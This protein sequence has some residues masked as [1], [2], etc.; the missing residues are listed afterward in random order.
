M[1]PSTPHSAQA[2]SRRRWSLRAQLYLLI[3]SVIVP[4]AA[5]MGYVIY[6]QAKER[7]EE[8]AAAAYR[9]AEITAADVERVVRNSA[10][11]L[12]VVAELP[13]V[14]SLETGR[15]DR[16]AADVAVLAGEYDNLVTAD[17]QGRVICSAQALQ[18]ERRLDSRHGLDEVVAHQKLVIGALNQGGTA[19]KWVIPL[20]Y[21]VRGESGAV[22]GVIALTLDV[23]RLHPVEAGAQL[24]D[25]S[26]VVVIDDKSTIIARSIE[27]DKY[28]SQRPSDSPAFQAVLAQKRGTV[29]AIGPDGIERIYGF[30][31]IRGTR[32]Y[33]MA[34]IP[35]DT[36]AEHV[37]AST[38]QHLAFV[39]PVI[40]A[41]LLL[42]LY[43]K[44]RIERPIAQIAEVAR[45]VG[46][47][48]F[49]VRAPETGPAEVVAV[50]R[51]FNFMIESVS[52]QRRSLEES[53]ARLQSVLRAVQ[54]V[55]YSGSV[56]WSRMY[57]ISSATEKL[58]GRPPE[59]FHAKTGLWLD[60]IVDEDRPV[61]KRQMETVTKLGKFEG[62]YRIRRPDGAIRWVYDRAWLVK[63]NVGKPLRVDGIAVDVTDRRDAEA[64][65]R[66]SELRFRSIAE[67]SPVPLCI[68]A[69]PSG[70]M[71]YVNDAFVA[72]FGMSRDD[73]V[74]K[75]AADH[76]ANPADRSL[77]LEKLYTEGKI[78]GL[79]LAIKRP[80]GRI[81][82]VVAAARLGDFNGEAA[83]FTG[84]ADITPRKQAE[85][86][87]RA[88][89]E[90]FRTLV[91]ALAEGVVL[92]DASGRIVTCNAAAERIL[93]LTRE[94]LLGR[95]SS[96]PN[97]GAVREDGS[98]FPSREHPAMLTLASGEPQNDVVMGVLRPDDAR[99]WIA[100]NS[101]PLFYP[102]AQ[103]PYAVVVSFSDITA[104]KVAE[105]AMLRS[106]AQL[107]GIIESAMDAVITVDEKHR[108]RLFNA[109]AE[110]MFGCRSEDMIGQ[111]LDRLL[112][113]RHDS[114]FEAFNG[115]S[116]VGG[117]GT[118]SRV[119]GARA[120]GE[121][122][123]I[124]A[125][126]SQLEIDGRQ[127]FTVILRDI[128]ERARA[129]A[130]IRE[131]NESLERRVV[132][133]TAELQYANKEL[134]SFSYSVSH[135]LRA[136]L[137]SINGFA[138]ILDETERERLTDEGR[139]LLERIKRSAGKMGQLI[140]DILRFSRI[141]R[142]GLQRSEVDMGA[143]AR[144]V[145]D[146][147]KDSYPQVEVRI[148]AL[149]TVIGDAT[150]LHQVWLNLI[151]NALKF[152]A[153][154]SRPQVEIGL[155]EAEGEAAFFVRDNGAGF[156]MQYASR[157]FGVFQR[158][159]SEADF[160]G[161]GVGLAIVK[162]IIERHKGRIWAEA[163]LDQGATFFF[164]I[165]PLQAA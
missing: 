163:A 99:V 91:S 76:Y 135:D 40:L 13:A 69:F 127:I 125:S 77:V 80:D 62:S 45:K 68:F 65:L 81:F 35:A 20:S 151:E 90:R 27:A 5:L 41:V 105:T 78:S 155:L 120:S 96:D 74:G 39:A 164:T 145:Y 94:Q 3:A 83:A 154:V 24:S 66:E 53:Q 19:G 73:Y 156:D 26:V 158:M 160:P 137:R 57:F 85:Q 102:E 52:A 14:R 71:R 112:P 101:R 75:A 86:S 123:P 8:A 17:R 9:I 48:Q 100:I 92:H 10:K 159:H 22:T 46:T 54:E 23:M 131:L 139:Q 152:S 119:T 47:G 128:T 33:S 146:E 43:L 157:L 61:V 88:S 106:E 162:R 161:T 148:A 37:W 142:A 72:S 93:G 136:P 110:S 126:I 56:D 114:L 12:S 133:R 98:P 97:W 15:C 107:A 84:Y 49:D 58:H 51:H 104:R 50:S 111:P 31:P 63:D 129:E 36:V 95:S 138:H 64:A 153:K 103:R 147:I 130:E 21:P 38:R 89:E 124:E 44:R 79:E 67:A 150:M 18:S 29:R 34:G 87:L 55:V 143:L 132:E 60:L 108:I 144:S 116:T 121:E 82:W 115:S 28:I 117:T 59:E 30:M 149:P 165:G 11:F 16:F 25:G 140:D 70:T 141:S 2:R 6:A 4:L 113:L 134:E 7:T 42:G 1:T 32:W 122:F 118:T 109:A